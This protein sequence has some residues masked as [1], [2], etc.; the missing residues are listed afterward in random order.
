MA[1]VAEIDGLTVPTGAP[2]VPSPAAAY[3]VRLLDS[4]LGV[5]TY[6]GAAM[7]VRRETAGGAGDDDEADIAF[8]TSLTDPTISLD[9][10]ISNASAGVT[11]TTL[12]QFLNVGTV[13][14]TTYTNPDSLTDTASCLTDSWYDQSG[15]AN[16]A[17]QATHGSQPQ[18]HSGA[19]DTDLIL[20]NGK[21]ALS[22][23]GSQYL[24][25]SSIT[26]SSDLCFANVQTH[27]V[28]DAA[29]GGAVAHFG[30]YA[31]STTL[32]RWRFSASNLSSDITGFPAFTVGNQYTTL[33]NRYSGVI[34]ASYNGSASNVGGSP[35]TPNTGV[36]VFYQLMAGN[37][38]GSLGLDGNSQEI[39]YWQSDQSSNR[40]GIE[41]NINSNYLI[42][43]PTDAPTSG[44]LA[45]Y[46]GA[47]AAYSVRQLSD[48]AILCMRIRRDMGAGNPG[49]DDEINIGFD[50]NGDLDTQA[51]ADFCTT[52]TGYV[53][54]WWDQSVNGNHADQPVGGT[55][56]NA[57]QPQI[58]NGTAVITANG[59][60]ALDFDGTNDVLISP[61][62]TVTDGELLQSAVFVADANAGGVVSCD[63]SP[64]RVA[65][66][67]VFE[68][69][70]LLRLL[71]FNSSGGI[72]NNVSA[73]A[74]ATG[75]Q[76]LATS[77]ILSGQGEVFVDGS[78][79]LFGTFN[80]R[81][82][83]TTIQIAKA[84]PFGSYFDGRVQ[85]VLHW[86]SQ[87]TNRTGI[88]ENINSNYL[89]YQPT[90]QPTSGLLY[91]YGSA[92]GGTDAAAA[93][94][95]RQ[96]SDKAVI[97]MRIRRDMGV[98]NP[99][100]DDEINIGFDTNGDLD[101][102]AISDFCGTGT[103]WV[104]R[105]WDQSVNG[106]HA[107][108]P[109][110]GTGSNGN[111][112]QIYNGT[113]VIEENGKPGLDFD[114]IADNMK[115][116]FGSQKAQPN[117]IVC[118]IRNDTT[119]FPTGGFRVIYSGFNNTFARNQLE[120]LQTTGYLNMYAG[121]SSLSSTVIPT[122]QTLLNNLVD[123]V[124]S[125]MFLNGTSI[126]QSDAGSFATDGL[127]IGSRFNSQY[128]FEGVF[129]ELIF[130]NADQSTNRSGIETDIDTYY[131][132]PG[133]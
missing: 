92:T 126:A 10:A 13:N 132:I 46:T 57:F 80:V 37:G 125:E 28:S 59:K 81:T 79:T 26:F 85:E 42:Y 99:G 25:H 87:Q 122:T 76:T 88:E 86:P 50:S 1:S 127:T 47:A 119:V 96:L 107:D 95:V 5:P 67:I 121:G 17:E 32:L 98:G 124:N 93:Y 45:T 133:M 60:P 117:Q 115:A 11:A 77:Q 9:S 110:G 34:T 35:G 109:V 69:T 73:T 118:V 106:N 4:A 90:D 3:S 40:T 49:D 94:S 91:D 41:E 54:R 39:I 65:Q 36:P 16:H 53:T 113:A 97:C 72:D 128:F 100:D 112:P 38:T 66:T 27:Q 58:Y 111:Q 21:P 104:T 2:A 130:W 55:G 33:F 74:N 116:Q 62:M 12:G 75:T 103:G 64:V 20:E 123:G 56:S 105:W 83:A 68:S 8:D 22:T 30:S 15:N 108:Q 7:R 61:T 24:T 44:L 71:T 29:Y 120:A 43:Q 18:I 129:Q 14:G 131:Q 84:T 63:S 101:T 48:K 70:S 52:G 102:Q 114:G 31:V 19:V 78:G 82:D 51:I 6:T 89:I 23:N